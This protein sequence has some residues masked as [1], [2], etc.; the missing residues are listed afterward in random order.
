[1]LQ[2]ETTGDHIEAWERRLPNQCREIGIVGWIKER[3][4]SG[5]AIEIRKQARRDV[6]LLVEIEDEALP[7]L[8]LT[9]PRNQPA[10]VR[11]ADSPFEVE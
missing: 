8:L 6:A 3:I 11:F 2:R 10:G 4:R 5:T 1:M 7:L 9:D